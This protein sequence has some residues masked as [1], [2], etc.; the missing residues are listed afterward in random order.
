MP[1]LFEHE[2]TA[3]YVGLRAATEHSDYQVGVDGGRGVD[4]LLGT[5]SRRH[6]DIDLHH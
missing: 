1:E 4:A 2:V 5:Q 3:V 6:D